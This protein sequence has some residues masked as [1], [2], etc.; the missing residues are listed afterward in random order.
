MFNKFPQNYCL[1][2]IDK[3]TLEQKIAQLF[4]LQVFAD[5][6]IQE[7]HSLTDFIAKYGVGHIHLVHGDFNQVVPTV[8][9][10][11][12]LALEK[13]GIP[14]CFGADC[15]LGL[16]HSFKFG[17][18]L[19]W[20]MAIGASEKPNYAYFT[21]MITA[22]EARTCGID[23]LYGPVADVI[24]N[25][26][27]TV[28]MS[29]SFGSNPSKVSEFVANYV[30]GCQSQGVV[31]TLK[32]FPGHG[33]AVEDSHIALPI[34]KSSEDFIS[35]YHLQPF[36]EGI[37]AGA[38]AM[39]TAHVV[40]PC[41]DNLPATIS[42]IIMTKLLRQKLGFQG[43]VITDSMQMCAISKFLPRQQE[44]YA[45]SAIQAGCDIVLHP[46]RYDA[47]IGLFKQN[48]DQGIIT[49]QT[50]NQAV[51]RVLAVKEWL[52]PY[53][54][55]QSETSSA[56]ENNCQ[57]GQL[58]D[59][60]DHIASECITL[61]PQSVFEPLPSGELDIVV[62]TDTKQHTVEVPNKCADIIS[63]ERPQSTVYQIEEEMPIL[64]WQDITRKLQISTRQVVLIILCPLTWFKG[65]SLLP[66]TMTKK[67]GELL[68]KRDVH[69]TI[70]FGSPYIA[71]HVPGKVKYCG[72]GPSM[73]CQKA[74]AEV[75][76]GYYPPKGKLPVLW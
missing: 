24:T 21:G 42:P 41:F 73:P 69:S 7:N 75:L 59:M 47:V 13:S 46:G 2:K 63:E 39:M 34:D 31:A 67:I 62:V 3:L 11:Q 18:D 35:Q 33:Q 28:I 68:D 20:Q 56:C 52:L 61:L 74:G 40:Y 70:I 8:E 65:R 64:D 27:N 58:H 38:K 29:R 50:I 44:E 60:A 30:Q 66:E 48:L 23:V 71:K 37:K 15:E 17:T 49:E 4:G 6:L 76:L 32:H 14:I 55:Q 51:S 1:P 53:Q 72:Y 16:R 10:L 54:K 19:P 9:Y 22:Q 12:N 26:Q 5:T 45:V 57:N 36:M 43:L 25:Y